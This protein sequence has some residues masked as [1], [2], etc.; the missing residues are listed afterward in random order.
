MICFDVCTAGGSP[1]GASLPFCSFPA[2]WL[3]FTPMKELQRGPLQSDEWVLIIDPT[4]RRHIVRLKA[5]DLFHHRRFGHLRH[6]QMIGQP[7]GLRFG[8]SN[9]TQVI[10]LR[11][12]FEDFVLG[13][14][15][16]RTQIIYP[17]DL[18]F[19]LIRGDIFPGARVLEA[20]IGSAAAALLLLRFLGPE[21]E[22]ISYERR[23]EFIEPARDTIE[24]VRKMW[25]DSGARHVI[26][27]RDV[28]EGIEERDLDTILLDVPEP[29]HSIP[30]AAEAV[31]PGGTLVCWLPTALQVYD[32][33]RRLQGD[34]HWA[35]VETAEL[36]LR[37]WDVSP[38]S[39]R[40][41]HRMVGHTG[42][43]I[44]ARRVEPQ[45]TA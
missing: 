43:L 22:L 23:E 12:T 19:L 6:D 10:C 30:S 26:Q 25:G 5:G 45:K 34:P 8:T 15:R 42:F 41:R 7:P 18:G 20:G 21:G 16:R 4:G 9:G 11:P 13:K 17:K 31:R 39:I 44:S 14:L 1:T 3:L 24:K 40:P 28:Y 38:Q 36:L 33:V 29:H 27:C 35:Q 32:L 37:H 2:D